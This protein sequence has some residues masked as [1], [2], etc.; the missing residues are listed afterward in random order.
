VQI[1]IYTNCRKKLL[2]LMAGAWVLSSVIIRNCPPRHK[3][4]SRLKHHQLVLNQTSAQWSFG[5]LYA[6]NC[7]IKFIKEISFNCIRWQL[8]IFLLVSLQ[9]C[10]IIFAKCVSDCSNK[11]EECRPFVDTVVITSTDLCTDPRPLLD[12]II[13][14]LFK[15]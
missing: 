3:L 15:H 9:L 13:I 10:L 6:L 4:S 14:Y 1:I 8:K 7:V 11:C 12:S 5:R 2:T